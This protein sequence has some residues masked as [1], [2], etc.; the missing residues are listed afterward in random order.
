MNK[1]LKFGTYHITVHVTIDEIIDLNDHF[2]KAEW[3]EM[4][5]R[6]QEAWLDEYIESQAI[7]DM[8]INYKFNA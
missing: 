6:E 2:D 3:F 8:E 4:K 7:T 1:K 5:P